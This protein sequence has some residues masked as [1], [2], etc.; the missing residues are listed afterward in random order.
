MARGSGEYFDLPAL[1][2]MDSLDVRKLADIIPPLSV[3][4]YFDLLSQFVDL[5]PGVAV[6]INRFAN[7]EDNAKAYRHVN[8]IVPLL[9][10]LGCTKFSANFYSILDAYGKAGNWRLSA[11][12]AKKVIDDF[13]EFRAQILA[14]RK[15][16]T[17]TASDAPD[18][19]LSLKEYLRRIEDEEFNRKLVVLAVDDSPDI[20]KAIL[21]LLRDEYKVVPLANPTM[22]ENTLKQV[23][24]ELFLLDYKMPEISGFDLVP[25]IR[26]FKEH[27]DTPIIFITSEGTVDHVSM[28]LALG[29]CDFIVKPFKA[30]VLREKIAKHIV[31]K[32]QI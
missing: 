4:G 30:D 8:D 20:L 27:Q 14:A 13:N 3:G 16:T 31:R 1:L 12:L 11:E 26:G 28:A 7:F 15:V 21:S 23:T 22:L 19:T 10:R 25:V 29:A 5:A 2:K 6:G 32:K 18:E 24:P 9:E 17:A